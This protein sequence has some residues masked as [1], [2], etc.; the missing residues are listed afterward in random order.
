LLAI[1]WLLEAFQAS[2][3]VNGLMSIVATTIPRPAAEAIQSQIDAA[4]GPSRGTLT[5]GALLALAAALWTLA[6]AVRGVMQALNRIYTVE[7]R[8]PWPKRWGISFLLGG[9][10]GLLLVAALAVIM[11]GNAA[12]TEIAQATGWGVLF[13]W[14]WTTLTWTAL[15]AAVTAAFALVYYVGPD[16]QQRFRWVSPGAVVAVLLWLLFTAAFSVY[17]NRFANFDRTYGVFVGVVVLLLYLYGT[18]LILLAGAEMNHVLEM[19]DPAGKNDG[20][21]DLPM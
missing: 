1:T 18:A 12:A 10:L 15:A 8:R 2:D 19:N 13:E 5:A 16:V 11:L 7:E 14:S 17:V 3:L 4:G 9:A 20:E 21:R 6:S